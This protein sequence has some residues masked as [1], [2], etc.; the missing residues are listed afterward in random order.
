MNEMNYKQ[1]YGTP[2][3]MVITVEPQIFIC[4]SPDGNDPMEERDN[5]QFGEWGN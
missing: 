3:A 5:G 1:E 2:I 4:Q